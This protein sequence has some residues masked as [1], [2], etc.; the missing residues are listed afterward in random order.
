M[1]NLQ[2]YFQG[3]KYTTIVFKDFQGILWL[4]EPCSHHLVW[5]SDLAATC[6]RKEWLDI[7]EEFMP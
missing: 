6:I 1:R 5:I 4:R 7:K 3:L 2:N